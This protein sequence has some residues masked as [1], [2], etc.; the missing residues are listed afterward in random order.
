MTELSIVLPAYEQAVNLDH[1]IPRIKTVAGR[2]ASS[3]E[4]TV[5]DAPERRDST[6]DV[7][8]R[9]EVC[10]LARVGVSLYGEAVRTGIGA[11]HGLRVVFM[12]ADG[13]HNRICFRSCRARAKMV[14]WSSLH[15]CQWWR[16]RKFLYSCGDKLGRKCRLLCYTMIPL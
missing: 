9:H 12:D 11:A 2:L 16:R 10:W 8:A 15:A 5:I 1:L 4:I 6:P 13:S 3:Y 7:C 14:T